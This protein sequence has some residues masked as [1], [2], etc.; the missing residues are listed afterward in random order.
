[1][2]YITNYMKHYNI[3]EQ[4]IVLCKAKSEECLGVAVDLHHI[5]FKS[6]GGKDNVENLIPI[7]RNCH[8]LAHAKILTQEYLYAK[9][10]N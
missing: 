10:K 7:C 4:D 2:S 6:Q 3:G 9:N 8:N 5:V 1:M